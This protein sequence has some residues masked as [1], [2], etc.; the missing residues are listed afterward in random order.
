MTAARSIL[1]ITRIASFHLYVSSYD[2]PHVDVLGKTLEWMTLHGTSD[3]IAAYDE[4]EFSCFA[5]FP[6]GF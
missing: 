3:S 6:E 2:I 4:E 1:S 5:H